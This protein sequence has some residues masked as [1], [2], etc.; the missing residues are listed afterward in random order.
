MD[1]RKPKIFKILSIIVISILLF[2]FI[3]IIPIRGTMLRTV[4]IKMFS[5]ISEFEGIARYKTKRL[6]EEDDKHFWELNAIDSH[7][8]EYSYKGNKYTIFAYSFAMKEGARIYFRR[9]TAMNKGT[10]FDYFRR[11]NYYFGQD[12]MVL[13]GS[14]VYCITSNSGFDDFYDFIDYLNK[15]FST[16]LITL[17]D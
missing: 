7:H 1:K 9:V 3:V 14:N 13:S 8:Y 16:K 10:D 15:S 11:G 17:N 2:V 4:E 5:N 6:S 12:L